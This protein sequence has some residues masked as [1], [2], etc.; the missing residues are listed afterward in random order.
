MDDILIGTP[1]SVQRD[2]A[3]KMDSIAI[4][5]TVSPSQL[6]DSATRADIAE[7]AYVLWQERGC[8]NGSAEDDWLEAEQKVR[9]R[10]NT[11]SLT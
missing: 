4:P 1:G 2:I 10:V 6:F 7:L 3:T 11:G 5:T 8:P 9:E